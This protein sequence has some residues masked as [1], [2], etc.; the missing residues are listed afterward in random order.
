ML[1]KYVKRKRNVNILFII[2]TLTI[3][4]AENQLHKLVEGLDKSKY[5]ITVCCTTMGG[6]FIDRFETIDCKPIILGKKHKLDFSVLIRLIDIIK[7]RKIDMVHTWMFTANMWG[8]LAAIICNTKVIISS[9]RTTSTCKSTIQKLINRVLT[10]FT[11]I[12][13]ANSQGVKNSLI[14]IERIPPSKIKVIYNGIDLPLFH[15][16][17]NMAIKHKYDINENTIVIGNVCRFDMAKDLDTFVEMAYLLV[18]KYEDLRFLI[19]GG[20]YLSKEVPYLEHIIRRI[21]VLELSDKI[22][23]TGFVE[24]VPEFLSVINIF[25]QTSTRE[26]LPNAL[27]EAMAMGKAVVA[28]AVGGTS[29]LINDGINGYLVSPKDVNAM[30]NKVRILINNPVLRSR[31]GEAAQMTIQQNFSLQT[32][33]EKTQLLYE[34]LYEKKVS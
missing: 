20:A 21:N 28:T 17:S 15:G 6:A 34:E 11:D 16:L 4:G 31:F 13:L 8:R 29:E 33:V 1:R 10:L 5:K 22:A 23:I 30:C 25:V 32:M 24:N 9:E 18:K 7:K 14:A 2:P 19:I 12:I 26:G 27:M 3:G